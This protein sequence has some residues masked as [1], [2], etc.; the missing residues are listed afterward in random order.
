MNRPCF[1]LG[2]APFWGFPVFDPLFH[3]R[4]VTVAGVAWHCSFGP[5]G[6]AEALRTARKK[7]IIQLGALP[8]S[9]P[10]DPNLSRKPSE[11]QGKTAIGF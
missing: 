8:H 9:E 11:P 1:H 10:R 4:D 7:D 3:F 5:Q 6:A 2:L